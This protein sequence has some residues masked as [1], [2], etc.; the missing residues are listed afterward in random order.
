M[1]SVKWC[2][3]P[4]T[5][6]TNQRGKDENQKGAEG[7]GL[8]HGVTDGYLHTARRAEFMLLPCTL[9]FLNALGSL[10]PNVQKQGNS[11]IK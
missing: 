11:N 10:N 8:C 6:P 5:V 7:K 1:G 9:E 2:V 3:R 4:S